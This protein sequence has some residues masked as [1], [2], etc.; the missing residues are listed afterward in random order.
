M[1][2]IEELAKRIA[3]QVRP[4]VPINVALWDAADIAGY[5]RRSTA[6]V[7][8][9]VVCLPDF[10]RPIRLPGRGGVGKSHPLWKAVEVIE[11]AES[12]HESMARGRP[13]K[14]G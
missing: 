8:E 4:A 11:W 10:P 5:L 9:H 13:R 6:V 1:S 7:R 2:D 14:T 3:D 12:H